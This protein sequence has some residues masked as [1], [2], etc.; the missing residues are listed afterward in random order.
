MVLLFTITLYTSIVGLMTLLL[1]KR[2]ELTSGKTLFMSVRPRVNGF[3]HN[4]LFFVE[5]VVPAIIRHLVKRLW[6]LL[7]TQ[8]K[9]LLARAVVSFE[10]KLEHM[11][12]LVREKTE[13]PKSGGQASAFLR[14]VAEHKKSLQKRTKK[15]RVIVEE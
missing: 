7:R 15:E 8:A 11:L 1:L 14:E 5:Y 3:F 9:L 6:H 12:H 10:Q 13:A 4:A 2:F